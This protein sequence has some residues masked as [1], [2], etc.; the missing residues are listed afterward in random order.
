MRGVNVGGG[1]RGGTWEYILGGVWIVETGGRG[2]E[3]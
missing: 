3:R 2:E 1:G